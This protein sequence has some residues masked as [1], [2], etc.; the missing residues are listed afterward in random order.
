M[1]KTLQT[2]QYFNNQHCEWLS[3][4]L[5]IGA[6]EEDDDE[7]EEE[8][9]LFYYFRN[10]NLYIVSNACVCVWLSGGCT[11]KHKLH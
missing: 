4:Q 8:V 6:K 9:G 2:K 1:T 7:K 11:C 5:V 10:I 3:D